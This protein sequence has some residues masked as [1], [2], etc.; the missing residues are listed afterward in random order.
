MS[1]LGR[2]QRLSKIG[3]EAPEDE[4]FDPRKALLVSLKSLHLLILSMQ[5]FAF[6][7]NIN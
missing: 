3:Q 5:D 6:T 4:D 2:L 1:G 7:R